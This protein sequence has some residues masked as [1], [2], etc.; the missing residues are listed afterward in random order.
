[1]QVVS[2][3]LSP[4]SIPS[5]PR[6]RLVR[7]ESLEPKRLGNPSCQKWCMVGN[8]NLEW[9]L[10]SF[11]G[12]ILCCHK[13]DWA[14][15]WATRP[16]ITS[17]RGLWDNCD[18]CL[19]NCLLFPSTFFADK[20]QWRTRREQQRKGNARPHWQWQGRPNTVPACYGQWYNTASWVTQNA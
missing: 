7:N 5:P 18:K 8:A 1:M 13:V 14:G 9:I 16:S 10:L 15:E 17:E 19:W 2:S 6:N 4:E 11:G 12:R 3:S 20:E